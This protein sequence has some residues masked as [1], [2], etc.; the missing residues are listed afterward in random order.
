MVH[1]MGITVI[2]TAVPSAAELA[3]LP[4]LGFDGATGP[5]VKEKG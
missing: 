1:N 4:E 5:A 3:L 2:A